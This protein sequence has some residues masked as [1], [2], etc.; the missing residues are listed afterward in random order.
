MHRPLLSLTIFLA[1]LTSLVPA[2]ARADATS[3]AG[4]AYDAGARAYDAKDYATAARAFALADERVPSARALELAMASA[5]L[6]GDASLGMDLVV[7]AERRA[8]D[9]TL[10]KLAR[11]LR[12]KHA[13]KVGSVT[14]ECAAARACHG[15][16]E[17]RTLVPGLPRHASPGPRA[18]RVTSDDGTTTTL[19]VEVAIGRDA[20]V[21]APGPS[22]SGPERA[23]EAPVIVVGPPRGLPPAFFGITAGATVVVAAVAAGLTVHTGNLHDDFRR[24]PSP[25]TSDAGSD[26]QTAARIAWGATAALFVSSVVLFVVSDFRGDRA[27]VAVGPGTVGVVGRF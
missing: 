24:A 6:A 13:G 10:T 16:L 12:A 3:E 5:L 26:A 18:V 1:S 9:G 14:L 2:R 25:A 20:A 19:T 23:E 22:P 7:R 11:E 27:R 4:E 17:G 15:D 21:R 8:V